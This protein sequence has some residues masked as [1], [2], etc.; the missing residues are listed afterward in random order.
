MNVNSGEEEEEEE[1][2]SGRFVVWFIYSFS[3]SPTP[4]LDLHS[5]FL[6]QWTDT[7]HRARVETIVSM[8]FLW[9]YGLSKETI[10]R[11]CSVSWFV[12]PI[13]WL[14][15]VLLNIVDPRLSAINEIF[16]RIITLRT[17]QTRNASFFP[18]KFDR[19]P[20]VC[21]WYSMRTA[22]KTTDD[23]EI[24]WVDNAVRYVRT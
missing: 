18:S 16:H 24:L 23:G 14:S 15:I 5:F 13:D 22:E 21:I 6:D 4:G 7:E 19:D 12:I 3:P 10:L 9:T 11:G 17:T 20:N 2:S 1:R 8:C